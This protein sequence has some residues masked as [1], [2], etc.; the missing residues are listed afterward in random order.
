MTIQ[1]CMCK[2]VKVENE[3]IGRYQPTLY[4]SHSYCPDCFEESKLKMLA[5]QA[6]ARAARV[7]KTAVVA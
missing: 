2:K 3:W 1:C 4:A 7:A 6:A 5:E